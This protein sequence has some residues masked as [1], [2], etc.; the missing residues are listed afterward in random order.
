MNVLRPPTPVSESQ[1][2]LFSGVSHPHSW[3]SA[4]R[5]GKCAAQECSYYSYGGLRGILLD[6]PDFWSLHPMHFLP[7]LFS[8]FLKDFGK[9]YVFIIETMKLPAGAWN[10]SGDIPVGELRGIA[11][12]EQVFQL[13]AKCCRDLRER[14]DGHIFF[15]ALNV[16]DVT[17]IQIGFFGQ[18][19]LGQSREFPIKTHLSPQGPTML[20]NVFK[21]WH[22]KPKQHRPD[23]AMEYTPFF[24]C[25]PLRACRRI[26][27]HEE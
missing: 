16:T 1:I 24:S 10:G 23:K 17:G 2:V 4:A 27:I 13:H 18:L 12:S 7:K 25:I 8:D 26:T 19:L 9:S 15:A 5:S 6:D 3:A 11:A 20:W 21:T 14:V 22:A